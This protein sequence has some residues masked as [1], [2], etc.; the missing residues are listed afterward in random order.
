[1]L[2]KIKRNSGKWGIK[3]FSPQALLS[4]SLICPRHADATCP[5][6]S[7]RV[8]L[9]SFYSALVLRCVIVVIRGST[10]LLYSLYSCP[11]RSR[12]TAKLLWSYLNEN[13]ARKRV[14]WPNTFIFNRSQKCLQFAKKSFLWLTYI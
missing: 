5:K 13:Q 9:P 10:V 14:G 2:R 7:L 11:H 8:K 4:R 1:M 3:F 6:T 12:L